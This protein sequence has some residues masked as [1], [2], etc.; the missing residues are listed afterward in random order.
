MVH[1]KVYMY[2]NNMLVAFFKIN[3]IFCFTIALFLLLRKKCFFVDL[4]VRVSNKVAV[5]M[6]RKLGYEVYRTVLEYYSGD[7]DEDAYGK[8]I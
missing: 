3:L 7:V 6:Y 4:F 2:C 5:N 1:S 8:E